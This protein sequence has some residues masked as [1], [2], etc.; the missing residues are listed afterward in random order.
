MLTVSLLVNGNLAHIKK[1]H[2]TSDA[3]WFQE[4]C[5]L[6]RTHQQIV[7]ALYTD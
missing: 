6:I 3:F 1:C 4:Q 2:V 7:I 5:W